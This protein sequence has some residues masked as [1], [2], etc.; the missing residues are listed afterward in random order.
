[1]QN[2][3]IQPKIHYEVEDA[4]PIRSVHLTEREDSFIEEGVQSGRFSD[5]SEVVREGLRL[6]EQ[7]ENQARLEWL[8]NATQ[9][10][11]D[12]AERGEYTTLPTPAAVHDFLH[13]LRIR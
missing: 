3:C 11:V 6:L 12:A 9:Q 8:R 5:A 1:M 13:N 7:N 2:G 4:M 10:G